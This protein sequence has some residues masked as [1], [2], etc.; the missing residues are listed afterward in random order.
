M[1]EYQEGGRGVTIRH[2]QDKANKTALPVINLIDAMR[3]G[4]VNYDIVN[5]SPA[6]DEELFRLVIVARSFF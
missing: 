3:S 2:F 6:T 1:N 5:P 4:V